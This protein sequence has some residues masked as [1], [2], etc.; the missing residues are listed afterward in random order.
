MVSFEQFVRPALLKSMGHRRIFRPVVKAVLHEELE[1][2]NDRPNL[3]RGRVSCN[4]KEY[5][6]T[7]TGKQGS[8]RLFSLVQGNGLI[9]LPPF[10]SLPAGSTV[11]VELYDSEFEMREKS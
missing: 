9:Y 2:T 3:I 11:D 7:S 4:D 5:V 8:N 1:N 10:T 6:V